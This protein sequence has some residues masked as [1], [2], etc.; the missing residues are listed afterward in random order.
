MA[1]DSSGNVYVG[2]FENPGKVVEYNSE[3]EDPKTVLE[4]N[5]S[6]AYLAFNNNGDL[7]VAENASGRGTSG[8]RR[9]PGNSIRHPSVNWT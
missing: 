4:A 8:T 1:V 7:Y 2:N 3:L 5:A 9:N 6:F